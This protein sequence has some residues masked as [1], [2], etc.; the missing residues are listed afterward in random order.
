MEP[1]GRE[2]EATPEALTAAPFAD[3]VARVVTE[4]FAPAVLLTVLVARDG[5]ATRSR[6]SVGV[7]D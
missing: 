5:R 6:H 7:F 2:P 3:R 4:V 1:M